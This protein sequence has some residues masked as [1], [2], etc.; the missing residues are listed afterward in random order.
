MRL[1][2][3]GEVLLSFT[4]NRISKLRAFYDEGEMHF[5]IGLDDLKDQTDHLTSE[6]WDEFG[7][8]YVEQRYEF[9][10]L[11]ELK[12]HFSIV[13]LFTVFETFLRRMLRL[14][15][16]P[17][18]AVV[19]KRI[20]EMYLDDMKK[21]FSNLGVEITKPSCDWQA[22]MGIK[23][24]RNCITHSDGRAD[25]QRAK[26]L[27]NYG[28]LVD[29]SRMVLPDGYFENSVDLVEAACKRIARN[30]QNILKEKHV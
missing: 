29:Q 27:M 20:M 17:A 30:C 11:L 21:E 3:V 8:F 2:I 4:D 19:V 15:H 22:I 6:E 23:E 28:I 5:N 9:E 16:H 12:K 1:S 26:K 24:V 10:E 14:L 18:D 7:D 25:K 13:G